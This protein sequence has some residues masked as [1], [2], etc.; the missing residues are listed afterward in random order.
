MLIRYR[1]LPPGR[2]RDRLQRQLDIAAGIAG[3]L[4]D[5]AGLIGGSWD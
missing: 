2:E 4:Q 5:L 3:E 1:A